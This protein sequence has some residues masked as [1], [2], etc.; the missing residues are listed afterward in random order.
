[1]PYAYPGP[2]ASTTRIAVPLSVLTL[3]VWCYPQF[4]INELLT[5]RADRLEY[6]YGRY[7]PP[8]ALRPRYALS[9][10]EM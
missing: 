10:T 5:I 6:Y 8:I 2:E 9:G 7:R 3:C 4:I 1:M